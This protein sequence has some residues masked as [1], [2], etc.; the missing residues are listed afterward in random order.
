MPRRAPRVSPDRSV[1]PLEDS[2]L[3]S[4][5]SSRSIELA[6]VPHELK[7]VHFER[8]SRQ[9]EVKFVPRERRVVSEK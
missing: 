9:Q 3:H 5:G 1:V 8:C 6:L 4:S 7:A 2:S